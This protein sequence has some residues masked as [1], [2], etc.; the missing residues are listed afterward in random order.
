MVQLETTP[1][2]RCVTLLSRPGPYCNR[3]LLPYYVYVEIVNG[4]P[5]DRPTADICVTLCHAPMQG[6]CGRVSGG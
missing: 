5:T 4:R 1:L 3:R 2:S 6:V